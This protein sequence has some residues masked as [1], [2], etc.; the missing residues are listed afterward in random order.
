MSAT[1]LNSD[2][3]SSSLNHS[4]IPG[5][6]T[7]IALSTVVAKIVPVLFKISRLSNRFILISPSPSFCYSVVAASLKS[8]LLDLPSSSFIIV[9]ADSIVSVGGSQGISEFCRSDKHCTCCQPTG[10]P[11]E[12]PSEPVSRPSA[13][14]RSPSA[15]VQDVGM[16]HGRADMPVTQQLLNHPDTVAVKVSLTLFRS[17]PSPVPW[18]GYRDSSLP[19]ARLATAVHDSYNKDELRFDD[20]QDSIRKDVREAASDILVKDS[21]TFRRFKNTAD[22]VLNGFDESRGKRRVAFGVVE[23]CFPVF[24]KCFGV[25]LPSHRRTASRTLLR[26]S[27]PGIPSTRPLRTSSR[28]RFASATHS[29]SI[30]PSSSASKLSTRRSASCARDSVGRLMACLASFFMVVAILKTYL[31]RI[32]SSSGSADSDGFIE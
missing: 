3:L 4:Y 5:I 31:N 13:G 29:R 16:N 23:S 32:E 10:P 18:L 20:I 7:P 9:S 17:V 12:R 21:P 1:W 27:S 24:L 22:G 15:T 26:A 11:V 25:K 28:L 6:R 19:E 8:R 14:L 2:F 30:C